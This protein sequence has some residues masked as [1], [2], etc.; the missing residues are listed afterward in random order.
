MGV[1]G[2]Q[3]LSRVSFH[4]SVMMLPECHLLQLTVSEYVSD[5]L[6]IISKCLSMVSLLFHI[7]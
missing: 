1:V 7:S 3:N 6:W 5:L 2:V 4:L